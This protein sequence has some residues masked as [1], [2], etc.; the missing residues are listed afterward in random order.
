[1]VNLGLGTASK[2][3]E[4]FRLDFEVFPVT[5][6]FLKCVRIENAFLW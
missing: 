2:E 4:S 1:M 5:E 3:K 6:N